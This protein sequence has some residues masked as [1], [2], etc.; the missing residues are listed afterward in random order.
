VKLV[1]AAIYAEELPHRVAIGRRRIQVA[2]ARSP[3]SRSVP[4]SHRRSSPAGH[5]AIDR[6]AGPC[7]QF[8]AGRRREGQ[9]RRLSRHGRRN[10]RAGALH[11]FQGTDPPDPIANFELF[12]HGLC[13]AE[14]SEV[15][16]D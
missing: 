13:E 5:G 15:R 7:L 12:R 8:L 4:R 10:G 6:H 2:H 1:P 3:H 11:A 16:C 9:V 14:L